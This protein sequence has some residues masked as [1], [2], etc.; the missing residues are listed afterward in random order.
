ML[1][2]VTLPPAN[3]CPPAPL[4]A[5]RLLP[6]AMMTSLLPLLIISAEVMLP[7][8]S[9]VKNTNRLAFCVMDARTPD[10]V[11]PILPL[12]LASILISPAV[13]L[14]IASFKLKSPVCVV[15]LTPFLVVKPV[16][17]TPVAPLPITNAPLLV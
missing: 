11:L 16:V 17:A 3:T 5:N 2:C 6:A 1:P 15:T 7:L 8:P 13:E 14:L 12:P 9:V 10:N 4:P